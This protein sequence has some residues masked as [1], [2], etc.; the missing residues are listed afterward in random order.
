MKKY[1]LILVLIILLTICYLFQFNSI[2]CS[3]KETF[4]QSEPNQQNQPTQSELNNNPITFSS[5]LSCIIVFIIIFACCS[6][7]LNMF[8]PNII[9]PNANSTISGQHNGLEHLDGAK[10]YIIT[11][12]I[13]STSSQPIILTIPPNLNPQSGNF[14][15]NPQT[16]NVNLNPQASY[17]QV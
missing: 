6:F 16:S 4:E 5:S 1:I 13:P 11:Q 2:F 9:S 10:I 17:V 8:T 14:S 12:P 15:V 3:S 7:C